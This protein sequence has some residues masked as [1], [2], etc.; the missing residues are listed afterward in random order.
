MKRLLIGLAVL[1]AVGTAVAL[2]SGAFR[3]TASAQ[4]GYFGQAFNPPPVGWYGAYNMR[5]WNPMFNTNANVMWY[6]YTLPSQP[7][8]DQYFTESSGRFAISRTSDAIDVARDKEGVLNVKWQ[9]EP[10]AV[11]GMSVAF[12]DKDRNKLTEQSI[13]QL[14]A[15]AKVKPPEKTAYYRFTVEYVDG[16]TNTVTSLCEALA[17]TPVKEGAQPTP[18]PAPAKD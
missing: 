4:G 13:T 3:T 9:G 15:E 10:R 18:A 5:P 2:T 11:Q 1:I 16:S 17:P 7:W 12:L 6:P 14:P 8:T